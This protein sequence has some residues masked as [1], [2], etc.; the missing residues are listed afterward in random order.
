MRL[1]N[2]KQLLWRCLGRKMKDK[3]TRYEKGSAF[4]CSSVAFI[5]EKDSCPDMSSLIR[6]QTTW[7]IHLRPSPKEKKCRNSAARKLLMAAN[8]RNFLC[9]RIQRLSMFSSRQPKMAN[10]W[11]TRSR[12][13]AQFPGERSKQRRYPL[14]GNDNGLFTPIL[15]C[16]TQP[17][18]QIVVPEHTKRGKVQQDSSL[19]AVK[20]RKF[21]KG[22]GEV[23]KWRGSISPDQPFQPYWTR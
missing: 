20:K 6:S 15:G 5:V 17:D 8:Q 22:G 4:S 12:L 9:Q 2:E 14:H 13:A 1:Q 3:G 21:V 7:I 10:E 18:S 19:V 23:T 11:T 16:G